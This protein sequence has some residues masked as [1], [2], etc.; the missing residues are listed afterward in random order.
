MPVLSERRPEPSA[1]HANVNGLGPRLEETRV[2][3]LAFAFVSLQDTRL[4]EATGAATLA[5]TWPRYRAYG[6]FHS[7]EG[8]ACHLLVHAGFAQREIVRETRHRHRLIAIEVNLPDGAPL[9]VASY[10]APPAEN[11]GPLSGPL[12]NLVLH[13]PRALLLGDLNARSVELGCRRT[14][15]NGDVLVE[16]LEGINV[17]VLNDPGQPTYYSNAQLAFDCLDWALATRPAARLFSCRLGEDIGSDHLPLLVERIRP[18]G[19]RQRQQQQRSPTAP[20]RWRTSRVQAWEPFRTSLLEQLDAK[21]FLPPPPD[22]STPAEVDERVADLVAAFQAAADACLSRSTPRCAGELRLPWKIRC[23]ITERRRLRLRLRRR[24][25]DL[26]VRT[27]ASRLQREISKGISDLRQEQMEAHTEMLRAGPRGLNGLTGPRD[28]WSTVRGYFCPAP[29]PPPPL[30]SDSGLPPSVDAADRAAA[31]GRH[32]EIACGGLNDPAF[33]EDFYEETER[34]VGHYCDHE[35]RPLNELPARQQPTFQETLP[36]GSMV[37]EDPTRQVSPAE[38]AS[39]ISRLHRGKAPGRDGVSSDLLKEAPPV[40]LDLLAGV[41]SS[42]LALGWVPACWRSAVVRML[43]KAGRSLTRPADYRPISLSPVMGKLLEAIFARR[44][45]RLVNQRSLLPPEQTAFQPASGAIEQVL[46]L[47]Q[48]AGQALNAGLATTVVSL[49]VAKAFDTVW[50][51]GLLR[52]CMELLPAP[53]ARWIAAF[54]RE[55]QMAVLE[56]GCVSPAFPLGTGVPQGSPLSPLLFILFVASMPLPRGELEGATVYADDV[57][58]WCSDTTPAAAW[59]NLQPHLDGVTTW[60]R[61]WRLRLS[62]EKTQLAFF[63][64]QRPLPATWTPDVRLLGEPLVWRDHLDLLGV[65]LDRRL[66]LQP[67]ALRLAARVAPRTLALRRLMAISWRVPAWIG[68]LLYKVMI[69]SVLVYAAPVAIMAGFSAWRLL[70][71]TE[72]RG[73]RA[74]TRSRIDLPTAELHARSRVPPL[75]EEVTRL[76]SV[77]LGRLRERGA[78]RLLSAFIPERPQHPGRVRW[79]TPLERAFAGMDDTEQ[80]RVRTW[81]RDHLGSQPPSSLRRKPPSSRSR[82]SQALHRPPD[83]WGVSPFDA[84]STATPNL[85][86]PWTPQAWR[87]P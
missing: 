17:S 68:V 54:L 29:P 85:L 18:G 58:L 30:E 62:P 22:P 52:T 19:R 6:F 51:A 55:R 69:R 47:A 80:N 59:S 27:E 81:L 9:V 32:L 66:H 21:G 49:D 65:R 36:S 25:D 72:R 63:S 23:L 82:P 39:A 40:V 70:E 37:E 78:K 24:P 11:N 84:T 50:H 31:F 75:R 10:Y 3:S 4:R 16:A 33:D 48:R 8:P 71:R 57:A 77:F 46:L 86:W 79:D 83:L 15:A 26:V 53:T 87:P 43:P 12:L 74:A 41:F 20:P 7:E 61:R 35:L 73:L 76:A 67:H 28:F 42:S 34:L 56:D 2:A 13:H 5:R 14:N 1:F 60:C 44:L 64:R 38:V 45:L